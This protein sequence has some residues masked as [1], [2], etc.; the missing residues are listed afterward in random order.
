MIKLSE[1]AYLPAIIESVMMFK[2]LHARVGGSRLWVQHWIGPVSENAGRLDKVA[3]YT[4]FNGLFSEDIWPL[5]M[6]KSDTLLFPGYVWFWLKVRANYSP[7]DEKALDCCS[8]FRISRRRLF[9]ETF[10]RAALPTVDFN[11]DCNNPYLT[12]N[13]IWGWAQ[14]VLGW[15]I[16]HHEEPSWLIRLPAVRPWM[17]STQDCCSDNYS[18]DWCRF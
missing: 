14:T 18:H 13:L 1:Y 10:T 11:Y 5:V 15:S 17:L 12:V 3:H 8:W 6:G 16:H 9:V 2:S 7:F 4:F